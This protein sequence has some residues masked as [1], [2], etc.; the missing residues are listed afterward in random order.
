LQTRQSDEEPRHI[1][2]LRI[3]TDRKQTV[4]IRATKSSEKQYQELR[5]PNQ[6]TVKNRCSNNQGFMKNDET[7][8]EQE[9]QKQSQERPSGVSLNQAKMND[10]TGLIEPYD[11]MSGIMA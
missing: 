8:K 4:T 6:E 1:P 3:R 5:R 10:V 7:N 9:W 2:E 11:T